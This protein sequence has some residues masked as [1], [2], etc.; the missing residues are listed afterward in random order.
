M[1]KMHVTEERC[2]LKMTDK[3]IQWQGLSR[4]ETN[5]MSNN[6]HE[7]SHVFSGIEV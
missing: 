7:P 5:A 4:G 1:N 2:V 3:T 6:Q